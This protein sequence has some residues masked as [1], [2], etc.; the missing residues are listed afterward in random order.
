MV[1]D[2]SRSLVQLLIEKMVPEPIAQP[3]YIGLAPPTDKGDL[4]LSLFL[5]SI[6]ENGDFRQ[7]RLISRGTDQLQYPPMTVNL[8]YM[9]TAHSTAE[10]QNRALDEQRILGR[11]MQVF[12]DH[13]ILRNPYLQGTLAEQDEEL[14]IV[15]EDLNL[16]AAINLFPNTSY[17]CSVGYMVG[18]VHL[19]STRVQTTKRVLEK[20]IHL[21]G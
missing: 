4:Q 7:T 19:D 2:V 14:R 20:N 11:A 8:R 9:I 5:Y 15:L 16:D 1:A 21:Q 18:P 13:S 3:E 6:T 12:Y 17:K 10:L